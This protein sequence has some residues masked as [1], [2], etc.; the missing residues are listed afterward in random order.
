MTVLNQRRAQILDATNEKD[1]A[2][3]Y[4]LVQFT[5]CETG[6]KKRTKCHNLHEESEQTG[7]HQEWISAGLRSCML[8]F[9]VMK[10]IMSNRLLNCIINPVSVQVGLGFIIYL[11][12]WFK[13]QQNLFV[14]ARVQQICFWVMKRLWNPHGYTLKGLGVSHMAVCRL[15]PKFIQFLFP[16]SRGEVNRMTAWSLIFIWKINLKECTAKRTN[17]P[18]LSQYFEMTVEDIFV[19]CSPYSLLIFFFFRFSTGWTV[20]WN[21]VLWRGWNVRSMWLWQC[22]DTAE[23]NMYE[24]SWKGNTQG[25]ECSSSSS[26]ESHWTLSLCQLHVLWQHIKEEP[27]SLA[28]EPCFV[29]PLPARNRT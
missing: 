10:F 27:G 21:A 24:D 16:L 11:F 13:D 1:S 9:V 6:G 15:S 2:L 8:L 12:T 29:Y 25:S 4:I 14:N 7:V 18:P 19:D 5:W 26:T 3:G 22:T 20:N 28:C 17:I 23:R